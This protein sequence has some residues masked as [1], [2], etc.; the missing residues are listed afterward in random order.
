MITGPLALALTPGQSHDVIMFAATAEGG[1]VL[2][3]RIVGRADAQQAVR[4]TS[5]PS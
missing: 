3:G 2:G 5:W 4:R 1:L